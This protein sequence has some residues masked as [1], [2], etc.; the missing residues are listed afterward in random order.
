MTDRTKAIEE[1]S[2]ALFQLA[3]DLAKSDRAFRMS[4]PPQDSD[5][6]TLMC[7]IAGEDIPYLLAEV[8]RL[9][10]ERDALREKI[11]TLESLSGLKYIEIFGEINK[12]KRG[13]YGARVDWPG[14][15]CNCADPENLKIHDDLCDMLEAMAYNEHDVCT[16]S[17]G[18]WGAIQVCREQWRDR[19]RSAL[20]QAE[21]ALKHAD[22]GLTYAFDDCG[23]QYYNN[24]NEHVQKA[25]TAIARLKGE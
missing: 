13:K 17:V 21:G 19:L 3:V 11:T 12:L 5:S 14:N 1:R 7:K 2:K 18:I 15:R 9:E 6:D 22:A 10:G 20:E 25:L 4:I 8:A 24:V 16:A 23:D